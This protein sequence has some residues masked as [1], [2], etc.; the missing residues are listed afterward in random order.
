MR[1]LQA[2]VSV[3]LHPPGTFHGSQAIRSAAPHLIEFSAHR[4]C[5][6]RITLAEVSQRQIAGI[7]AAGSPFDRKIDPSAAAAA[8]NRT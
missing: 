4:F 7:R 8:P 6:D 1:L 5:G 3:E 2:G